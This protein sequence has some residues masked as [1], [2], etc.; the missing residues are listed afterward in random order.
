MPEREIK[1]C[2]GMEQTHT[3]NEVAK[4]RGCVCIPSGAPSFLLSGGVTV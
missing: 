4:S 3:Y 2:P 1:L